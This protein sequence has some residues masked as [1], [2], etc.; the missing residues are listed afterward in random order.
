MYNHIMTLYFLAPQPPRNVA[1]MEETV[2]TSTITLS[3]SPPS[4]EQFFGYI[5]EYEGTGFSTELGRTPA[6]S[7][8]P[9]HQES[10]TLKGLTP[11]TSY[12]IKIS[13]FV[14][15]DDVTTRSNIVTRL[16]TTSK[17]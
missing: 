12:S 14:E 15:Y 9:R 5:L 13:S 17:S 11:G 4:Q 6:T 16:G 7:F 2:T 3:W 10:V 1:V 8:L